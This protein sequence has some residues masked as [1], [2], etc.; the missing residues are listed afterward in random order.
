MEDLVPDEESGEGGESS[1]SAQILDAL[2]GELAFSREGMNA[3]VVREVD[4]AP[5]LDKYLGDRGPAMLGDSEFR[6]AVHFPQAVKS[7]NAHEVSNEG[8]TLKWRYRLSECKDKPMKLSMVT[9]IPL[10]WWVY[11]V[12]GLVAL[13]ILCVAWLVLKKLKTKA[14]S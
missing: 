3:H 1:K 9:P 8:K 7:S 4:L 14:K 2:L 10:P 5:L 13:L 12:L 11:V 6:Y